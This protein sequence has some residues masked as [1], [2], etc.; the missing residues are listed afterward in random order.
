MSSEIPTLVQTSSNLGII[1]SYDNTIKFEFMVRSSDSHELKIATSQI[2]SQFELATNQ[3]LKLDL[4]NSVQINEKFPYLDIKITKALTAWKHDPNNPL[5][6]ILVDSHQEILGFM[7][8]IEAVHA[9]LECG[10]LKS[11]LPNCHFISFGPMIENAHS[12]QESVKIKSVESCFKLL[13][14]VISKLS[15]EI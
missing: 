15:Q 4:D 14:S 10:A 2:I 5:I 12:P 3:K 7:P 1:S 11:Y 9:G 8:K 6:Q 13:N